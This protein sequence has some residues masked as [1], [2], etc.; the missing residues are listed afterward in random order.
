LKEI[1]AMPD[2]AARMRSL[3][4]AYVTGFGVLAAV[5][6]FATLSITLLQVFCRYFL[7]TSLIWAEEMCRYLMIWMCFL[8]VG[9]AFMRGELMAL[10]SVVNSMSRRM[11]AFVLVP[12]YLA[13]VAFLFVLV[14]YGLLYA[15]RN[16]RQTIAALDFIWLEIAGRESGISVFWI[17]IS[18]PVGCAILAMHLLASAI[19]IAADVRDDSKKPG[20]PK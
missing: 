6:M 2:L 3:Q 20:V 1:S 12:A 18:A 5:L 8:F 14:Y 19:G 4:T 7:F 13:S 17:Y 9:M 16:T 15:G 10:D 11:R